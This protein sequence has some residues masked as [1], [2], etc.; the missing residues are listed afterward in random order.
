MMGSTLTS[1]TAD[2]EYARECLMFLGFVLN[3]KKWSMVPEQRL[4]NLGF[5]IDS[6]TMN[7]S[8]PDARR[9][10]LSSLT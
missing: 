6:Q 9:L 5:L 4:D 1:T 3:D 10:R 8:L 2:L 7:L